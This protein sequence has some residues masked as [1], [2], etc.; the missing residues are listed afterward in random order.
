[1]NLMKNMFLFQQYI[2]KRMS[3]GRGCSVVLTECKR[4]CTVLAASVVLLMLSLTGCGGDMTVED[5]GPSYYFSITTIDQN[6]GESDLSN[7]VA[8]QTYKVPQSTL[9]W[10]QPQSYSN[11][12][13]LTAADVKTYRLYVGASPDRFLTTYEVGTATT[14]VLST[15]TTTWP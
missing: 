13:T 10:D 1:M 3:E 9:I 11:G 15:V 7:V 12:D 14:L 6:D 8:I 4:L 5:S 2:L